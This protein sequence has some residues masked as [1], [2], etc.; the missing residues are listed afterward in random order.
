M[1]EVATATND[2]STSTAVVVTNMRD[3]MSNYRLMLMF[4]QFLRSKIDN[5]KSEDPV[6]KKTSEQWL[7][8]VTICEKVFELPEDETEQKVNFMV[9]IG[10]KFLG[11]SPD[12]YNMA[13]LNQLNRKELICH[14]N[15]LSKGVITEPDD[16][17]LRDGYEYVYGKLD[18][19]HDL[20]RKTSKHT[21]RS[22]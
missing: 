3:T 20:F 11:R 15:N 8:F 4:R 16:S 21:I 9:E 14:C 19:K 12:G 5:N 18:Q 2:K 10:E 17:L 6:K 1:K 22:M 13:L 7:D